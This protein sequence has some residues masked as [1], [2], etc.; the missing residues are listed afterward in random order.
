[1]FSNALLSAP[2]SSSPRLDKLSLDEEISFKNIA[3]LT[4]R[5]FSFNASRVFCVSKALKVIVDDLLGYPSASLFSPF[6]FSI[7][8]FC[9]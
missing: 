3:A 5:F 2:N 9:F 6:F 7:L 1:M 8:V 4:S